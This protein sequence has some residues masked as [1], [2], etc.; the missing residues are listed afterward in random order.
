[1]TNN[2]NT[3]LTNISVTD[4][5]G[6][7]VSCPV[8][9]LNAGASTT[10]T[11]SGTATAGQYMNLGTVT[12]ITPSGATLTG[13][14]PSH[15]FG[16]SGT[17]DIEKSTNGQDADNAPGPS[18]PVGSAVTWE[19]VVTNNTNADITGISVVDS[20]GVNVSCTTTTLAAGA[21]TTCMA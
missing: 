18:I 1:M 16:E 13:S 3:D 9:S 6:V 15:Y 14:D 11:A 10:C 19:Y 2:T 5:Q 20:Q 8:T 7:S 12:G 17:L 21:S 4:S